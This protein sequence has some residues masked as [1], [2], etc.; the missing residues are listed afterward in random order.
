MLE[1]FSYTVLEAMSC[2]LVPIVSKIELY[3]EELGDFLIGTDAFD[4]DGFVQIL[5][6]FANGNS[7][8]DSAALSNHVKAHFNERR[9]LVS[10]QNLYEEVGLL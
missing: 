10:Y 9:F 2:G 7:K 1:S 4:S 3:F 5:L 8:V 6:D